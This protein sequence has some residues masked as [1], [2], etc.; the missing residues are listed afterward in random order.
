[1]SKL[2]IVAH[3]HAKPEKVDLVKIELLKLIETTRTEKGCLNYDLHQDDENS[4]HFLFF[5]NWES[6]EIWQAHM[7]APHIVAFLETTEGAVENVTL[8]E[9]TQIG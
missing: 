5:E 4:A 6:R 7:E 8:T 1:M 3:I 2:T 9:M